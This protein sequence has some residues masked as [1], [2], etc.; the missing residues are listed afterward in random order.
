MD[1]IEKME[2]RLAHLMRTVDELSDEVARHRLEIDRL[3]RLTQMLAAR[4]ADRE[5][6]GA[7]VVG[8]ERPPH[9]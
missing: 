5:A 7:E 1:R 8:D 2:E 3:T 4:E 9:W 6:A